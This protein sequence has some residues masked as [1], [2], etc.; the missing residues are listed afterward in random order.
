M[1]NY[2]NSAGV[3]Y[4]IVSNGELLFP[5]DAVKITD[6]DG[7]VTDLGN[8]SASQVLTKNGG[9]LSIV[10]IL[11]IGG[12]A[13]VIPPGMTGTVTT[14]ISALSGATI[15][16]GGTATI[17]TAV[18]A[19]SGMTVN[20]D[21]GKAT[22]G[23]NL[24]AGAL[25]GST[26][27]LTNGG[28][29]S[30]G[31]GLVAL[32]NGSTINFGK[33][34]GNFIANAGGTLLDL[35]A[36]TIN[37]FDAAKDFISFENL[38][39][40]PATYSIA[41]SLGSQQSITVYDAN[42][43]TIADVNV[44]GQHFTAG[45][46]SA[47][48]AGPLTVSSDGTSL[49][50][51]A[52]GSVCFLPGTLLST[53]TGEVAV[54]DVQVGDTLLT[55]ENGK[56]VAQPVVWVGSRRAE[57]RAGLP[58][59]EAGWPVRVR[60]NALAD[61]VPGKDLLITPE[62]C[63][64][65]DGQFVPVRMLVNGET[66]AYDQTIR[67]YTYYHVETAQHAVI[68]ADGALT[69]SYLDTGNRRAFRQAGTVV[70]IPGLARCWAEDAAAPLMTA[71]DA[72][73]PL[74]QRLAQRAEML[75]GAEVEETQ[76]LE[77]ATLTTESDL[78]LVTESGARINK[79][80]THNGRTIFIVP[81]HVKTVH[82]VSRASRPVDTIGPFVDDRRMLGVLVGRMMLQDST[83]EPR[84]LEPAAGTLMA[85]GWHAAEAGQTARWTNGEAA[86]SLGERKP[87]TFG[88]LMVEVLAGGPYR[89]EQAAAQVRA[90]S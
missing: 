89:L 10:S 12:G 90:V 17:T 59:D 81:P 27:N 40:T 72:V 51:E 37:G 73:E 14:L 23:N 15:Y 47:T 29:F 20:V 83:S 24:I 31:S 28:T 84:N 50:I 79:V 52:V 7:T 21:G 66:I 76:S 46:Y 45:K 25:S 63:L 61:G 26:I 62:H 55:F 19:L 42:G 13:Y 11:G 71:R 57:V 22:M 3:T 56:P 68:M 8:V 87:G 49:S 43:Q 35:S 75:R 85:S 70:R 33:G 69:E 58:L 64:Y 39:A 5:T 65:L 53:P 16:V 9:T 4:S 78:H 36:T 74:H 77:T 32:L 88:M 60:Q 82:L 48:G 34:G 1:T 6:P 41:N 67:A 86:V 80:R 2:T 18:S 54:E 30:N 38:S 44:S